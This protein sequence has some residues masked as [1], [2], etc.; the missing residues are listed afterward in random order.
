VFLSS[1]PIYVLMTII[2]THGDADG[3][4]CGSLIKMT[5]KY[6]DA[7]VIFTH[8]MGLIT[9]MKDLDD[10]LIITDIAIDARAYEEI[11]GIMEKITRSHSILCIDHHLTP[12]PLPPKVIDILDDQ[13]CATELVFRYFYKQLPKTA[14]RITCIGA[15]C[16]YA[17]NTL[18]MT[19]LMHRFERRTLYLDAGLMAQGLKNGVMDYNNLRDLVT[20]FSLGKYPCEILKLVDHALQVTREDK[21]TRKQIIKQYHTGQNIAWIENPEASKAKA[22]HW[23]MGDSGKILGITI[24]LREN[25]P[26]MADFTIRGRDLIDLRKVIPV[27]A[28]NLGGSGGG[29]R[30]AIGARIPRD[31]KEMFLKI[32]D[33]TIGALNIPLPHSIDDLVSLTPFVNKHK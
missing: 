18:L 10:D 29:H 9:D 14:D 33:N 27:L 15:I 17:E 2:L 4:C 24:I 13:V 32:I 31:K 3:I 28:Q 12:R 30:N 20:Q 16:E 7:Q 22:A 19:E 21:E 6:A 5:K 11:C 26:N 23:I 8:P 25:K 1:T